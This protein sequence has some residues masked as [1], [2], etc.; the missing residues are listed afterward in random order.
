MLNIF[1]E[2]QPIESANKVGILIHG[3]GATVSSILSLRD[4]L[5]LDEFAL[6]LP[7]ANNNTWYPYSFMA[8]DHMNE[9]FLTEAIQEIDHIVQDLLKQGFTSD[10]IYLFGFS[11]GACLSLEYAARNPKKYGAVVAFT[12]GLIGEQL[13]I[14]KY[15]GDFEQTPVFIGSSEEDMHVPLS[16]IDESVKVFKQMGAKVNT[17][18]FPDRYHTIRQEEVDWVNSNILTA[19]KKVVV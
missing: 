17:L 3:R 1:H 6:V 2:G 15:S 7:Q 18:I 4:H 9:P 13:D 10:K 12:G 11:Q 8:P 14:P 16:R 5:N 19:K